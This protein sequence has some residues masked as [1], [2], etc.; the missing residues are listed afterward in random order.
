MPDKQAK[1]SLGE[2]LLLEEDLLGYSDLYTER[3]FAIPDTYVVMAN[4]SRVFVDV[5]RAP[6]DITQE[7]EQ[8]EE[9]VVV[10]KTW[11]GKQIYKQE[12][13]VTEVAGRI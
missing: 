11:D 13:T 2:H 8:G 10:H 4:V 3:I 9:G 6:D 5:N 7:Y 1:G 12:P